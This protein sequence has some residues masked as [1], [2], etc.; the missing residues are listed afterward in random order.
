M[1]DSTNFN[2]FDDPDREVS[3]KHIDEMTDLTAIVIKKYESD[4][5]MFYSFIGAVIT[6]YFNGD[7]KIM[8]QFTEDL[9]KGTF[10]IERKDAKVKKFVND[11]RNKG[12]SREDIFNFIDSIEDEEETMG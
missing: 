10:S 9:F 4:P 5:S 7:Y 12:I 3:K 11:N 2:N 1:T 8:R 6:C